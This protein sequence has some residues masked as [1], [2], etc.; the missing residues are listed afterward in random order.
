MDTRK[1]ERQSGADI[2]AEFTGHLDGRVWA[3]SYAAAISSMFPGLRVVV[4]GVRPNPDFRPEIRRSKEAANGAGV[5]RP[6]AA[7]QGD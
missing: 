2:T 5:D 4:C 3:E 7:P 6:G 1:K